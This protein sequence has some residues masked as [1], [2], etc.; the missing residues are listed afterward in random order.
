MFFKR[1]KNLKAA[2]S[3]NSSIAF[4]KIY[5]NASLPES[6]FD[7]NGNPVVTF[8]VNQIR[9]SKYTAVNFLP[10][11]LFEQVRVACEPWQTVSDKSISLEK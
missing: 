8:P 6:Y 1:K 2:G 10:K 7:A 3:S 4:R 5:V 9:T 11:N